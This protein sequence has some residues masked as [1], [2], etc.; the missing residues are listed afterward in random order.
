[1]G[2]IYKCVGG[3]ANGRLKPKFIE[4]DLEDQEIHDFS[5]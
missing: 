4:E 3:H 2:I 5:T 1:M